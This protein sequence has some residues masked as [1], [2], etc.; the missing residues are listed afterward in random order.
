MSEIHVEQMAEVAKID[1]ILDGLREEL[2]RC[3]A[4]VR[5]YREAAEIRSSILMWRDMRDRMLA[6]PTPIEEAL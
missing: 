3:P 6:H 4:T 2:D 1:A 5:G